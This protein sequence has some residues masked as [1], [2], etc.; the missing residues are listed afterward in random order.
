MSES[1]SGLSV[2]FPW[3]VYAPYVNT[4]CFIVRVYMVSPLILLFFFKKVLVIFGPLVFNI[5]FRLSFSS[6]TKNPVWIL[7]GITLNPLNSL[8]RNL[9]LIE[10][11]KF[12]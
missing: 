6:S 8:E 12:F 4:T 5:N 2:M 3:L 7:I 1:A 10:S 11:F 9:L